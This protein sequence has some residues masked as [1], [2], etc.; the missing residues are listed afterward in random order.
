MVI[1]Q[2]RNDHAATSGRRPRSL[3]FWSII[4]TVCIGV[5][6]VLFREVYQTL[7][8]IPVAQKDLHF[9]DVIH[10]QDI[11]L[12]ARPASE[13]GGETVCDRS[14]LI[15][16]S[17]I[18]NIVHGRSIQSDD[19]APTELVRDRVV[20]SLHVAKVTMRILG[21][22]RDSVVT[23]LVPASASPA[24][25]V[26]PVLVVDVQLADSTVVVLGP[27]TIFGR[28]GPDIATRE[29]VLVRTTPPLVPDLADAVCGKF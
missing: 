20:L 22:R 24:E 6:G 21:L 2:E 16:T 17:V 28:L 29:T 13:V 19:I 1:K 3:T 18:S 9:G 25:A 11:A 15:G 12:R 27:G 26:G 14:L 7:V 4:V 5:V 8:I 23:I 10:P